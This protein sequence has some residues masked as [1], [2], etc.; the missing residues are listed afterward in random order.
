MP[1]PEDAVD[2]LH[3]QASFVDRKSMFFHHP[4]EKRLDR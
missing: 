1:V 2:Q 3:G 4:V